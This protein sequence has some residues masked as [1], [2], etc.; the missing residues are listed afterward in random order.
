MAIRSTPTSMALASG[1]GASGPVSPGVSGSAAA[2]SAPGDSTDDGAGRARRASGQSSV[3]SA[4]NAAAHQADGYSTRNR[5]Q[6]TTSAASQTASRQTVSRFSTVRCA[7]TTDYT[8][9][10]ST[11]QQLSSA[12][13]LPENAEH[14]RQDRSSSPAYHNLPLSPILLNRVAVPLRQ[15]LQ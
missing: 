4:P 13:I 1:S 3:N 5:P 11:Y 15:K 12:S 9:F 8:S 10:P 6:A 14:F 2:S 7:V